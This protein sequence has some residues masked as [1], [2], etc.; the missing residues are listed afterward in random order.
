MGRIPWADVRYNRRLKSPRAHYEAAVAAMVRR[1]AL[2]GYTAALVHRLL[3]A[4]R[5]QCASLA[6]YQHL[7]TDTRRRLASLRSDPGDAFAVWAALAGLADAHKKWHHKL[8]VE[9]AE[10]RLSWDGLMAAMAERACR[11]TKT[12]KGKGGD[13]A[14]VKVEEESGDEDAMVE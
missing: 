13:T 2:D 8:V 11:E 5:S 6:A 4:S 12:E 3:T 10:Q 1:A 14:A 9:A 7:L